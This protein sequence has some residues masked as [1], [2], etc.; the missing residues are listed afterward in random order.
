MARVLRGQVLGRATG[1]GTG[2]DPLAESASGS[3]SVT[4]TSASARTG[5]PRSVLA[6]QVHSPPPTR[7]RSEYVAI[8]SVAGRLGMNPETL[9][10][11]S[12]PVEVNSHQADG[13]A[14]PL[15]VTA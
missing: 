7:L 6:A 1:H 3:R 14:S 5:E 9:Q 12:R 8:R 4:S 11:W 13:T 15:T 2:I 10:D